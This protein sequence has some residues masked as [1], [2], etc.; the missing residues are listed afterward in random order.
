MPEVEERY[1]CIY[2]GREV[3]DAVEPAT[4]ACCG[5]VGHIELITE[6]EE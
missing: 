3:P 6:E 2:C 5:E 1:A 4:F